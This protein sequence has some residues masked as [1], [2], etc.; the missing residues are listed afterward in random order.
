[1]KIEKIEKTEKTGKTG[2]ASVRIIRL[3]CFL[4]ALAA[5]TAP[6]YSETPSVGGAGTPVGQWVAEHV[7]KDGI[8]SW[9]DFRPDGTFTMHIGVIVTSPI[10]RSGDTFTSPATTIKGSPVPTTYCVKGDTL[11]VKSPNS[12]EQIFLRIGP[13][14]SAAD[15]LLGKWKPIPPPSFDPDPEIAAQQKMMI[16][17]ILAFSANNTQSLRVPFSN[18]EGVWDV[19]THTF[20]LNN[21]P[22][23]TFQRTGPRLLLN[24]PPRGRKI[25]IYL[26]DPTS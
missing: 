3:V 4:L 10:T 12:Q 16:N 18:Y 11:H 7:S 1:M 25:E 8:G 6:A 24:Q 20:H 15:P 26:P 14:P 9:W 17:A 2:S 21:Q 5:G 13:A 23:Y 19:A 22:A